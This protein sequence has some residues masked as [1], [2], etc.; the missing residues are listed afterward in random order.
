MFVYA[1][2]SSIQ[3]RNNYTNLR[4]LNVDLMIEQERCII[5]K[6]VYA[7]QACADAILYITGWQS[8]VA[9]VAFVRDLTGV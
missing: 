7:Y 1:C 5:F 9:A 8:V 3:I 4:L 2:M 6:I